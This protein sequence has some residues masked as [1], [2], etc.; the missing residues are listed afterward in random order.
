[1][2]TLLNPVLGSLKKM[3]LFFPQLPS[4]LRASTASDPDTLTFDQAMADTAN[5]SKWIEAAQKEIASLEKN[6]TWR[7]VGM[8]DAKSKILPGT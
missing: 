5:V 6:G 2:G 4:R 3:E 8:D 1:M 7:E